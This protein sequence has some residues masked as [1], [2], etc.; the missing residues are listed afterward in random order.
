MRRLLAILTLGMMLGPVALLVGRSGPAQ[1]SLQCTLTGARIDSCCCET[2][3]GKP[4][5]T[6]AKQSIDS[7]CCIP[8][9]TSNSRKKH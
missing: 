3:N 1:G 7:C 9:D 2:R 6:L 4:Y 8:S 5:C